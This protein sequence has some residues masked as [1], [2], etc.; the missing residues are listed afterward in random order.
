MR[1]RPSPKQRQST[2]IPAAP[3][4]RVA[5][6]LRELAALDRAALVMRWT[7]AFGSAAPRHVQAPLL[8][9]ALGWHLQMAASGRGQVARQVHAVPLVKPAR[10]RVRPLVPGTRLLREWQGKTHHVTVTTKGFEYAG[11]KYGSLTAIAKR[12]TG[13]AWSGPLFFGLRP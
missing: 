8:R 9:L 11:A 6:G 5:D 12:I 1:N 4:L 3:N 13:T 2:A 10:P 7:V